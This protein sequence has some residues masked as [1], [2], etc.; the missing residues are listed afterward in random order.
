MADAQGVR[1]EDGA[2]ADA[3]QRAP[4]RR[5]RK[6]LGEASSSVWAALRDV[7]GLAIVDARP[8]GRA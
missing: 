3:I 4:E 6:K 8:L 2:P 5:R 7:G 1:Q